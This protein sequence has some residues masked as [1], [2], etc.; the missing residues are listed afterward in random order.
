MHGARPTSS[1]SVPC[2]G[3]ISPPVSA[4]LV[5]T[6][7]SRRR[8]PSSPPDSFSSAAAFRRIRPPLAASAADRIP[9]HRAC[10]PPPQIPTSKPGPSSTSGTLQDKR[11]P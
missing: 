3:C 7:P 4:A 8:T 11:T 5:V 2:P 10:P 6:C 9:W 1:C